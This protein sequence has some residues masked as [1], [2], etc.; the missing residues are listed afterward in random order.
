VRV[1]I[2]LSSVL[3]AFSAPVFAQSTKK[4]AAA[5]APVRDASVRKLLEVMHARKLVDALPQQTQTMMSGMVHQMLAG[6]TMTPAQQHAV[7][8]MVAKTAALMRD[9]FN[10]EHM[11]PMYLKVYEQTFSQAEVQSMIDFYSTPAG[12]A[13]VDKLPLVT[14]NVLAAMQERMAAMMP[15]IQQMAADMAKQ[16]KQ[17][18]AN[19]AKD[20]TQDGGSKAN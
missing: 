11:E 13:V 14:Q 17:E 5:T 3:L 10:W 9:E 20:G 12:Q 18:N 1:L 15:K 2:V 19:A 6:Q 7:D 8:D 4:D 16:I